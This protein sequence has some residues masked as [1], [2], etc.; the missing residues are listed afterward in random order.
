MDLCDRCLGRR[1]TGAIGAEQQREAAATHRAEHDLPEVAAADCTVCEDR[2]DLEQW[3]E[4]AAEALA[5]YEHQTFQVGT[6]FPVEC[7]AR[8]R[9]WKHLNPEIGDS[10][11]TESNRMLAPAVAARTGT[12][13][14]TDGRPDVV[15]SVDT[16][17]WTASARS[18]SLFLAGRYTKHRRDLP[19][20]HW[21]CRRCQGTR[22]YECDDT[23]VLYPDSVEDCIGGPA[24]EAFDAESYSFHGAGREDI[25]AL[26][27]GTGRPFVL[28][29]H[30][31]KHRTVDLAALE[32][33]I[34]DSTATRGTGV[35]ALRITEKAEVA[36]IKD[37]AYDKRYL[38]HCET[39]AEVSRDQVEAACKAMT[40]VVLEQ[41][42]PERVSHR[43]ADLVRKR[44]IHA[45]TLERYDDA[46]HFSVA[47]HA[48]SGAYIKEMVHSDE[49]RTTPSLTAAL[50]VPCR[51]ALL[52]VTDILDGHE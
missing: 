13:A 19:Q 17:F 45:M 15:V 1:I 12:E 14:V 32:A 30:D 38:A 7:E 37:G 2:W 20:T 4:L 42:T 48:E 25:D 31:P 49:G 43:R 47:V 36:T 40:G 5:P 51:V 39:E 28:E 6:V 24:K 3:V 8:E 33:A 21:P 10:I 52:D 23:G 27:L 46:T 9:E 18:N 41:R 11:R 34:N 44:S 50:G 22:C 29:L 35:T 26:M 16:R